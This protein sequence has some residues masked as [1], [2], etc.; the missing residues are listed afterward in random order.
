MRKV[1]SEFNEEKWA[2]ITTHP[3]YKPIIE[4]IKKKSDEFISCEPPRI[5]FSDM[6]IYFTEGSRQPFEKNR[7]EYVQ[8]LSNHLFMYLYTQDS[9]F[10]AFIEDIIWDMCGFETWSRPYSFNEGGELERRAINLDLAST[11]MGCLIAET[12]YLIGDK[13]HP[14]VYRRAKAEVQ[15]RIIDAYANNDDFWWMRTTLN[16]AAVC[17]GNILSTYIYLATDEEIEAQLPRLLKTLEH[18][19]SGFDE[20][21]CCLEGLGYWSYGFTHYCKGASMLRDYTDGKIDLF[22]DEKVHKIAKFQQ[23]AIINETEVIAFS[24]AAL[25]FSPLHHFSCFLKK[26]YPDIVFPPATPACE[27]GSLRTL[28]W[29]NPEYKSETLKPESVTFRGAQWFIYRSTVYNFACKGGSNNEPHNHNDIGSFVISKGGAGHS[30]FLD[31]G[32]GL[33]TRQYFDPELRYTHALASSRGHSVPI[34]DGNYQIVGK[35]KCTVTK[36]TENEYAFDMEKAYGL[37]NLTCLNRA[38]FCE[39]KGFWLT[40]TYSFKEVPE[41]ITERFVSYEEPKLEGGK[42]KVGE[43]YLVFDEDIFEISFAKEKVERWIN[44]TSYL[45]YTDLKV[46][47]PSKEFSVSVRFE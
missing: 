44:Q 4:D 34:I 13:I 33:Y 35:E 20:D 32:I 24:D 5:K 41:N 38:F 42:V 10:L 46:K 45:Y 16:W 2:E 14:L 12:L 26:E 22:K 29:M 1:F 6:H 31:P 40:D 7:E 8:R 19:I 25:N 36:S 43:S 18:Y 30:T 21:G 9:K 37:E 3:F 27:Y 11:D 47:N 28:C 15:R 17:A 39:E 23:N